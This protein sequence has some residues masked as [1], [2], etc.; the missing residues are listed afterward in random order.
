MFLNVLDDLLQWLEWHPHQFG[1][2]WID[3][4]V[5]LAL[6]VPFLWMARKIFLEVI[7]VNARI[8]EHDVRTAKNLEI[9]QQ[10]SVEQDGDTS[11]ERKKDK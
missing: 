5:G 9:L 4:L 7:K 3:Y 10:L 8:R 6:V 2:T 11:K 1:I